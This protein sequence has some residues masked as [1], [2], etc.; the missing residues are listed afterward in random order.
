METAF[1]KIQ[2]LEDPPRPSLPSL[3][4]LSAFDSSLTSKD[5]IIG[6][7]YVYPIIS[8]LRRFVPSVANLRRWLLYW[9]TASIAS[10]RDWPHH[11]CPRRMLPPALVLP[12]CP[13][14]SGPTRRRQPQRSFSASKRS[15]APHFS[16]P[17]RNA[18]LRHSRNRASLAVLA[19]DCAAGRAGSQ[20]ITAY[21]ATWK[22]IR[23]RR[24]SLIFVLRPQRP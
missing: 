21:F 23:F 4:P 6:E 1:D 24:S 11:R 22:K 17:N 20:L 2:T 18:P 3:K 16:G 9:S 14:L 19:H 15:K 12:C 5:Q 13:L 10:A 7:F 8:F